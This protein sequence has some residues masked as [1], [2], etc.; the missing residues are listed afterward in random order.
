M[1]CTS[2]GEVAHI[3]VPLL[4]DLNKIIVV[5]N[6][7]GKE[8]IL[9]ESLGASYPDAFSL[10]DE[11]VAQHAMTVNQDQ[12]GS[13]W[14]NPK[15]GDLTIVPV[16]T[17]TGNGNTCRDYFIRYTFIGGVGMYKTKVKGQACLKGKLWLVDSSTVSRP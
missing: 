14:H 9:F 17:M 10:D 13:T 12:V 8:S 5:E 7:L 11:R 1:G 4:G 2:T 3:Q 16:N 15:L 6:N